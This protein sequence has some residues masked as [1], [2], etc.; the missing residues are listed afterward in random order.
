M[1][2]QTHKQDRL[3][4]TALLSLAR[5]VMFH[6][7]E[8]YQVYKPLPLLIPLIIEMKWVNSEEYLEFPKQEWINVTM[9][10]LEKQ[11]LLI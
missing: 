11:R 10:S 2:P 5:S 8:L 7:K 1:Q 9:T 3:Q 4:Y 6:K